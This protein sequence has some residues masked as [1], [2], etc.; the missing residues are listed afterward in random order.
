MMGKQGGSEDDNAAAEDRHADTNDSK[1]EEGT[2]KDGPPDLSTPTS[3]PSNERVRHQ[4]GWRR[5]VRNFTPSWFVVNMGTGISSILLY[6]LPYNGRWLQYLSYVLFALNVLLFVV[7]LAISIL[8]YTLW[9]K[10]WGAMIR[11]PAQSL[12]I[13]CFPMGFGTIVN[14]IAFVCVPSW[15]GDWWKVAWAFWWI[16][17]VLAASTCLVM[18]F[19]MY[20]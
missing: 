9:P 12:F 17:A 16:D 1:L 15:G 4:H 2:V 10:I 8:R 7:F 6:N 3:N 11:H 20:V 13:G 14:M 5:V 18:P 19:I